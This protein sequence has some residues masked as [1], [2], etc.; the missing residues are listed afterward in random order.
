ML[1]LRAKAYA[2]PYPHV[3]CAQ[4]F[5][6][7]PLEALAEWLPQAGWRL[8]KH[9]FYE[10]WECVLSQSDVP[11]EAAA[12]FGPGTLHDLRAQMQEWF[13]VELTEDCRVVAHKLL[14]GQGIGPHTD[15]PAFGYE[16]HRLV[17]T[18]NLLHDDADGGHLLIMR[19]RGEADLCNV[20]RPLFNVGFAFEASEASFHCVADVYSN[21]RYSLIFN[22]THVGNGARAVSAVNAALRA[23]MEVPSASGGA[24]LD[25]LLGRGLSGIPHS[26]STFMEHLDGVYRLLRSW[27][28]PESTCRAGL[29]HS[30]YGTS[31]EPFASQSE[32]ATLEGLIG[33][34]A[35][36]IVYAYC[37]QQAPACP[38]VQRAV[39]HV[40]L[41]NYVEQL[42]RCHFDGMHWTNL[43]RYFRQVS[44]DLAEPARALAFAVFALDTA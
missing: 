1:N 31:V 37:V 2:T 42:P 41:A 40:R 39:A 32:R 13:S 36:S 30:A 18:P 29:F 38:E 26:H 14:P 21:A 16:T 7:A 12:L 43:R 19:G 17:V 3:I 44:S 4:V 10:Q 6:P 35:E 33:P 11:P 28:V 34:A 25:F 24:A 8:A 5:E 20:V 27:S 22:F 15:H 9:D 23:A